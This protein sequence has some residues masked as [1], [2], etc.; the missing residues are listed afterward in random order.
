MYCSHYTL[1]ST[2]PSPSISLCFHLPILLFNLFFMNTL[3]KHT[4]CTSRRPF[5]SVYSHKSPHSRRANCIACLLVGAYH[6]HNKFINLNPVP[7]HLLTLAAVSLIMFWESL[8]T[9]L[10]WR[11]L[12]I[13][14]IFFSRV[15]F[16]P[17]VTLLV[18]IADR[19]R[20]VFGYSH[21]LETACWA[22][23]CWQLHTHACTHIYLY[24]FMRTHVDMH[25]HTH[26]HTWR[27]TST[28]LRTPV[29]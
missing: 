8:C 15:F 5:H 12:Y 11:N 20:Q 3:E 19:K 1:S 9:M 21:V 17:S 22:S 29:M 16:P 26:I 24:I 18:V 27:C 4:I 6:L 23:C 14:F 28:H 13:F 2:S 10:C 25:R 7:H